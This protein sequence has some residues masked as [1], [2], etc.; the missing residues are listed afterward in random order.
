MG[1][2]KKTIAFNNKKVF[3]NYN[4]Y[5]RFE[6]GIKLV[7]SEVKSLRNGKANL[8]GAYCIFN[9]KGELFLRDSNI[10]IYDNAS[11]NNHEPKADRKLLLHKKELSKLKSKNDE[12]GMTI[13][14]IK[15]FLN[16]KGKFKVEIALAKGKNNSDK[17]EYIKDRETKRELKNLNNEY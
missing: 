15:L 10:S 13:V 9:E 3:F 17:R 8:N 12:K 7:G 16:E 5:D 11:Y 14:P 6:A 1:K 4:V 2:D